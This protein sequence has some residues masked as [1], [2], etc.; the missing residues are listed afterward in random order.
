MVP[1]DDVDDL[2][3]EDPDERAVWEEE[4]R[5]Y[6]AGLRWDKV[7]A[8]ARNRLVFQYHWSES[9]ANK[10]MDLYDRQVKERA[11]KEGISLPS[12]DDYWRAFWEAA[13][14]TDWSK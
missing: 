11:L 1:P 8:E 2:A 6:Q 4:E 5:R 3:P 7:R 10:F 14:K 12:F 9:G 13:A